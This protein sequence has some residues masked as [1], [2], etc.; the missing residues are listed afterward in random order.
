MNWKFKWIFISFFMNNTW[1]TIIFRVIIRNQSTHIQPKDSILVYY[2]GLWNLCDLHESTALFYRACV[3]I[4]MCNLDSFRLLC[5]LSLIDTI[6]CL[7]IAN[8]NL[9][10][11]FM[12]PEIHEYI[13]WILISIE[14]LQSQMC[15][16]YCIR[17]LYKIISFAYVANNCVMMSFLKSSRNLNCHIEN[18]FLNEIRYNAINSS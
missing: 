15:K 4:Y 11:M 13:R 9:S 8:L 12:Y 5:S 16:S 10:D 18:I 14:I 7:C 17:H 2:F 1:S 3:K 6:Y